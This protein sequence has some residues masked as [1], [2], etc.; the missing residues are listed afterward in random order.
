LRDGK[1]PSRLKVGEEA[2]SGE[3]QKNEGWTLERP[4]SRGEGK[5][6]VLVLE[7]ILPLVKGLLYEQSR[8]TKGSGRGEEE[9]K[10]NLQEKR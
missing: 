3:T 2:V 8:G 1:K 10:M 5:E 6:G 9:H 4:I 7:N